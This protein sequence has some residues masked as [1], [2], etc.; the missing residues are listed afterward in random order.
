MPASSGAALLSYCFRSECVLPD[1]WRTLADGCAVK[2][3]RSVLRGNQPEKS[4]LSQGATI[5]LLLSSRSWHSRSRQPGHLKWTVFSRGQISIQRKGRFRW[6]LFPI[7][8]PFDH[9]LHHPDDLF[10]LQLRNRRFC[11]QFQCGPRVDVVWSGHSNFCRSQGK[12]QAY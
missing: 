6:D 2:W 3:R 11:W 10:L 8:R 9:R 5:L 12:G 7:G 1:R 4:L